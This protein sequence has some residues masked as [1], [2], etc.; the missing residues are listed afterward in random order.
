MSRSIAYMIYPA[1]AAA[2]WASNIVAG[3]YL[4]G[5]GH[6]DGATLSF[7]RFLIATPLLAIGLALAGET[8][9]PRGMLGRLA[10]AGLLG[11]AAFNTLLY[12]SLGYISAAATAFMA[13]TATPIT[14]L[15]AAATGRERLRAIPMAGVALSLAGVYVLLREGIRVWGLL[16]LALALL[17]AVSWSIYTIIVDG[18]QR[19]YSP[20]E[21]LFWTM[22]FGT[23]ALA[24]LG[25]NRVD[26]GPLEWALILYVAVVPGI[27]GYLAWNIGVK[28][29]G[30]ALPSIFIPTIPLL[31]TLMEISLLGAKPGGGV[32]LGG[33]L[34]V[35]GVGLV[36]YE[37]I[38]G[39][40][41]GS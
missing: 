9:R 18:V 5:G 1:V 41:H 36:I 26:V 31:A 37:R 35:A 23:V 34:I 40:R 4:V 33:G 19:M 13:T 22:A 16:G 12:S 10:L 3:R 39:S 30:P 21:T 6:L 14:Y 24:P 28:V 2:T 38:K 11:V 20:G 17:A 7:Y 8:P 32:A 15:I 25:L 27:L 29:L